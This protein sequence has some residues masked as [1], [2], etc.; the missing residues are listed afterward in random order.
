MAEDINFLF[1]KLVEALNT[2]NVNDAESF[3]S[4]IASTKEISTIGRFL[5]LLKVSMIRY[6]RES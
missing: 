5:M 6:T 1:T 4:L 3:I 2:E